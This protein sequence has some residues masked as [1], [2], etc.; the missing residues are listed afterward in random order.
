MKHFVF[1]KSANEPDEGWELV[2]IDATLKEVR[3]HMNDRTI[4]P[5]P[6][7]WKFLVIKGKKLPVDFQAVVKF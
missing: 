4:Y 6:T 5:D 3:G 2:M 7:A 1:V